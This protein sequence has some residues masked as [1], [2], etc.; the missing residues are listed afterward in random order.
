M[1]YQIWHD[2][3]GALGHPG[4]TRSRTISGRGRSNSLI[5]TPGYR[6][7]GSSGRM[8]GAALDAAKFPRKYSDQSTVTTLVRQSSMDSVLCGSCSYV[9][10]GSPLSACSSAAA[11]AP[12]RSTWRRRSSLKPSVPSFLKKKLGMPSRQSSSGAS[13]S[14][15]Y[16]W[17]S[18]DT[19]IAYA[20]QQTPPT[21]LSEGRRGGPEESVINMEDASPKK[22]N[23]FL[24]LRTSICEPLVNPSVGMQQQC[25]HTIQAE[26]Y[27][28][29]DK[30]SDVAD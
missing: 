13:S 2:F 11:S 22:F 7:I 14:M 8:G 5:F 6:I 20:P 29:A 21:S 4:R 9:T 25:A 10:E 28:R 30:V 16:S 19:A 17:R 1:R 15:S 27:K 18:Q 26:D 12:K 23:L 3:T 24:V